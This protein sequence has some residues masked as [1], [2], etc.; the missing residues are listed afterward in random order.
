V[1]GEPLFTHVIRV[2]QLRFD[3]ALRAPRARALRG[4]AALYATVASTSG[5]QTTLELARPQSFR[6]D[7]ASLTADLDIT[8]LLALLHS[9]ERTTDVGGSYTITLL[10]RVRVRGRLGTVPLYTTFSPQMQFSVNQQELQPVLPGGGALTAARTAGAFDPTSAGSVSDRRAQPAFLSLGFARVAVAGARR[11]AIAAIAVLA[12]ALLAL[13]AVLRRRNRD[14]SQLIRA[15]YGRMIVA[16]ERVWQLPGVGVIDV[17]D[18]DALARIAEHYDRS[19]LHE[20]AEDGE[21][22]WVSDESGQFR[23]VVSCTAWAP[24]ERISEEYAPDTLVSEVYADELEL[25]GV[26]SASQA[27]PETDDAE[28]QEPSA[29]WTAEEVH[30]TR[31]YASRGPWGSPA[32][33]HGERHHSWLQGAW[34]GSSSRV[35]VF[36]QS[37]VNDDGRIH[38][39]CYRRCTGIAVPLR[40]Y[41]VEQPMSGAGL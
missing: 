20:V 15:R 6:G 22:F 28:G 21:A 38:I 1:T 25:G 34:P 37:G 41:R 18:I 9:V 31:V 8:S 19:I 10:P 16:V 39:G 40:E 26:I 3:Y 29:E 17:A 2:V 7:R 11:I 13:L 14:E 5:W 33:E 4:S 27:Q 35:G 32:R 30:D 24:Q 23:Y 36:P 12:C